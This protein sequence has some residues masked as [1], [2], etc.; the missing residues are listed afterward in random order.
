MTC[1]GDRI[2]EQ[3]VGCQFDRLILMRAW[4]S[5]PSPTVHDAILAL[6]DLED[7][8]DAQSPTQLARH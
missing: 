4:L 7:S 8:I 5:F 2:G 1:R 6:G 3:A